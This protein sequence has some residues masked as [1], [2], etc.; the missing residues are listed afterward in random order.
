MLAFSAVISLVLPR[1][2]ALAQDASDAAATAYQQALASYSAGDLKG[3]LANM[4]ESHRLSQR[5]ELL[6]NIARIE[7]E[8][9]DCKASL[10]DYRQYVQEVPQGR[11]R[12]AADQASQ[13]LALRCPDAVA[14]PP[15]APAAVAAVVVNEP[16]TPASKP[17]VEQPNQIPAEPAKSE[18]ASYWTPQRWIGWSLVAAGTVAGVGAVY[19][20]AAAL[21]ARDSFQ[22]SVNV[23]KMGGAP[24]DWSLEA[25]QHRDQHWM[26][27]LAVAGG[28]LLTGG[29]VV[30]V[31]APTRQNAD[32]T[33][34]LYLEP[35][36]LGAR[37]CHRF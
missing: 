11:Y 4:R 16:S 33:A 32:T 22:S 30:L 5:S 17:V 2:V 8:L 1:G 14:A 25:R 34:A 15:P 20:T 19:F 12:S 23:A 28:A 6:Y 36:L 29:V 21:D 37:F 3:A 26:T 24:A 35:G 10:A 13:E 9:G 7:S 31:L 18:P 27:G